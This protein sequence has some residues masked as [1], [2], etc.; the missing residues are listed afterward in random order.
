MADDLKA[1]LHDKFRQERPNLLS[2]TDG[3]DEYDLRRPLT[4]TGTNLLRPVKHPAGLE[5]AYLGGCLGRPTSTV[6]S[7][8]ED[9]TIGEGADMWATPDQTSDGAAGTPA[10]PIGDDPEFRPAFDARIV[11]AA[12]P[13]RP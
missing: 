10:D 3:L 12:D 8:T 4:P 2:K 9:G 11:A 6:L 7:W 5:F 13:F 1:I